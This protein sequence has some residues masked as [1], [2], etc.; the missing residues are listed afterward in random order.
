MRH[1]RVH[2][3]EKPF[4]VNTFWKEIIDEYFERTIWFHTYTFSCT[5]YCLQQ[6]VHAKEF[7]ANPCMAT[8]GHSTA[9]L[10]PV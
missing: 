10:Q 2:T 3:G 5:V 7:V 1:I 6:S 9:Y 8:Q 4:K